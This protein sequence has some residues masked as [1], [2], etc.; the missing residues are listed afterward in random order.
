MF[1]AV[2]DFLTGENGMSE[3]ELK[4]LGVD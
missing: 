4:R 3:D 1:E 2:L